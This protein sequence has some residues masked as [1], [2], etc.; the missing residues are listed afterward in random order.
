MFATTLHVSALSI[1]DCL[2]TAR[3][4]CGR[5]LAETPRQSFAV[6]G[7]EPPKPV[8]GP[9]FWQSGV[10]QIPWFKVD[11]NLGFHHKVIAAGNPAMGLWVRAGSICA[12][13]LTDGFIPEHMALAL[14][15]KAQA[16]K[17]VTVGLWDHAQ[18]GYR[19]HG[20]AERQPSKVDVEAERAAAKERM[21]LARERKRKAAQEASPQA[22]D[23]RS[24]DVRPNTARTNGEVRRSFGNPDPTRPDPSRPD[25]LNTSRE[26]AL[27]SADD[28]TAQTLVAEWLDHCTEPPPSRV[29]GQVARELKA[30]IDEGIDS[31]RIRAGLAEWN[32]KGLH[33]STIPSV[34]HGIGNRQAAPRKNDIDWEAAAARAAA[35]EAEP[36]RK[37]L[38]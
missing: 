35:R 18:G 28:A 10:V 1:C 27:P 17:L 13:Q 11:D 25:L 2:P 15:T 31:G 19:F 26:L 8:I 33:P 37:E 4:S 3:T 7:T 14:G 38:A 30:L 16:E 22:S 34:V 5:I 32:R 29:K 12:Q 6:N 21:R 20:W 23:M 24:E 9:G 36:I